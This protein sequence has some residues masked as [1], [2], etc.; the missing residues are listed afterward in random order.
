MIPSFLNLAILCLILLFNNVKEKKSDQ[1]FNFLSIIFIL[2]CIVFGR[3]NYNDSWWTGSIFKFIP[4]ALHTAPNYLPL[5]MIENISMY[6]WLLILL[7][8][9]F[10]NSKKIIMYRKPFISAIIILFTIL[11]LG[12]RYVLS[13]RRDAVHKDWVETQT[14]AL[15]NSPKNSKFIVNSGFDV[16]E[17]WTTLS[18]RP[19][20]I[21]DLS[22]GFLYFYTKEDAIYD[23]KRA[24]L[25]SAPNSYTSSIEDLEFF[26]SSFRKE[27]GG[28][29]LVWENNA[30]KLNLNVAYLNKSFT[31]YILSKL[32]NDSQ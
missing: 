14:W 32:N 19:R 7:V 25:P 29:Y 31:I 1:R 5:K 27:F 4:N 15:N 16:Y 28:D 3:A 2:L 11:T 21:A 23:Q 10:Y 30:T 20:L 18:R 12:G 17:S 26:Y 8:I 6:S 13:E 24:R 9:L 22:A